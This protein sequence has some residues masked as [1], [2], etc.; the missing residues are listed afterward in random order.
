M[1]LPLTISGDRDQLARR[2]EVE[3]RPPCCHD[4]SEQNLEVDQTTGYRIAHAVHTQFVGDCRNPARELV[5][6]L[7]SAHEE[8]GEKGTAPR[9][10]S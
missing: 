6:E 9:A 5:L 2:A 7:R 10:H 8:P 4:R 3:D 1:R